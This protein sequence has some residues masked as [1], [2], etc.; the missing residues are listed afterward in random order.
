VTV[1]FIGAGNMA[2][3]LARGWDEPVLATDGGSGRAAALVAEVGGKALGSNAA[4]AREADL[5]VLAHKRAQLAA[6]AEEIRGAERPV[7]SLLARTTLAEL[8]ELLPGTPVFR[9][10]PNTPVAVR[11][12]VCA[13]AEPDAPVDPDLRRAVHERFARV[14][15]VVVVPEALMRVAGGCAGVGPAY[16]AL[17]VEAQVDA[18]VRH[19]MPAERAAALVGET[20]AGSAALLRERGYDTLAVRRAVASPGGTTARGLAALERGGVRS[21]FA[22]AL[23]AV[24]AS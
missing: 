15:T 5:V 10:E 9:V 13:F 23:D 8:R 4:L 19:G 3:A 7:V 21:A 6:V 2:G 20:M 12:G 11:R 22:D 16:W 18:A 17:L 24:V 14:G 1:G